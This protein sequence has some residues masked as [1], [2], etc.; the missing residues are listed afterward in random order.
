MTYNILVPYL[1]L[2]LISKLILFLSTGIFQAKLDGVDYALRSKRLS[3]HEVIDVM[4][5]FRKCRDDAQ[6]LSFNFEYTSELPT[7]K[8]ELNGVTKDQDLKNYVM[9]PGCMYY[10]SEGCAMKGM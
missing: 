2:L 8:C 9:R 3:E 7:K 4:Q 1:S 6:C 5:C 10:E